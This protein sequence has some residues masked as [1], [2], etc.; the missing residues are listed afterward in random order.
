MDIRSGEGLARAGRVVRHR[1][2]GVLERHEPPAER[3]VPAVIDSPHSGRDYPDDFGHAAPRDLL[4]RAEDAYVDELI[5]DATAEGIAVLA[6]LFPRSYIDPNRHVADIDESLLA[7]PWPHGA[8]PSPRSERG[9]GL[10]RRLL[11][12]ELPIYDRALAVSE[13]EKRIARFYRPYHA[14]LKS[15]LDEAH[16]EFGA[17]WHVNCHS[18]KAMGRGRHAYPRADFVLGDLDGKACAAEFTALVNECLAGMGYS[19]RINDPFKGAE[20][21]ERYSD[22]DAGRHGLQ[23]EINRRL[24]L[25][26]ARIDKT[27]DFESLKADLRRLAATIADYARAQTAGG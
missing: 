18:M 1:L 26:E 13:V 14:T 2:D 7:E 19:V 20:L 23:I 4:R 3:R 10:L 9:L 5:V 27:A 25:D 16:A 24:Y 15:M 8:A 11:S 6:A 21:I 22:P 17:V 12:P